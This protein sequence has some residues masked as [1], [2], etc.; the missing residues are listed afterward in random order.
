LP[1]CEPGVVPLDHGTVFL[2]VDSPRVALGFS[3]CGADVFLLDDEPK[4]SKAEAVRLELT[5]PMRRDTCFRDRLLIR[6]DHFR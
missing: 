2:L 1:G 5:I 3:A 4:P 6:P